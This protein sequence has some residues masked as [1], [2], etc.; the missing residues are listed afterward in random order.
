ML[1]MSI[2]MFAM[3]GAEI[4]PSAA[5]WVC[6]ALYCADWLLYALFDD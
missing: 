2:V 1:G 6:F 3:I 5:Y 4:K